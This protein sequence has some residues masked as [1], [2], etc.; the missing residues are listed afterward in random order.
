MDVVQTNDIRTAYEIV[1]SGP[2]LVLIHGGF[3]DSAMWQPQ[4]DAFAQDY[5]VLRYDLRGHGRTGP[6]ARR[7]YTIE[8]LA[9][10]LKALLDALAIP[11]ATICGLSLGGM[12]AQAFAARYGQMID[13]LVLAG[14]AV[15][16]T[17]T[18]ADKLQ[19]YLIAP[20]WLMLLTIRLLGAR[21]L[22]DY[23]FRAARRMR[24]ADWLG[25]DPAVSEY[26][27]RTMLAI[28]TAEYV[29]IYGALYDFKAQDLRHIA[30]PTL[31]VN[32]QYEGRSVL[33]H[34]A[35]LQRMIPHA[36]LATV[37][38]AGH[39]VNMENPSAFN[40]ILRAFLEK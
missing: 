2:P 31:I 8:L 10:D 19:R 23:S 34:A 29:K 28:P 4:L 25:R 15:S 22:V 16:T 9:D 40:A 30:A 1:G 26:V 20:R 11:S 35:Y 38:N 6:S 37:S 36:R 39:T 21:R 18:L 7:R 5:R 24:G 27:R 33:A 32:G 17:L 13:R 3:V 12:I 14:T